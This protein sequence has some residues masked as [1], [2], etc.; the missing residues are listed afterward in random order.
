[1]KLKIYTKFLIQKIKKICLNEN[2]QWQTISIFRAY[3]SH[4]EIL[5]EQNKVL[6]KN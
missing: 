1:M 5:H 2:L 6:R 3:E 4:N